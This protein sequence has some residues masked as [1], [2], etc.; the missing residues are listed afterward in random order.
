MKKAIIILLSAALVAAC[1]EAD[2]DSETLSSG[3][4]KTGIVCTKV[5]GPLE[6]KTYLGLVNIDNVVYTGLRTER[7]A[8]FGGEKKSLD[9]T[10]VLDD[11]KSG[12]VYGITEEGTLIQNKME[13]IYPPK[14]IETSIMMGK[15]TYGD[16]TSW[17]IDSEMLQRPKS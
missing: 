4:E 14:D 6:I 12:E 7:S 17:E 13:S 11:G 3:Y 5:A 16:C 2:S 15:H 1:S 9:S 10:L 8:N